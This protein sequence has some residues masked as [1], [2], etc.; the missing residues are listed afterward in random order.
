MSKREEE[1]E[2]SGLV[3]NCE[4]YVIYMTNNTAYELIPINNIYAYE[5]Q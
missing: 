4:R 2:E 3:K 5:F 1:H